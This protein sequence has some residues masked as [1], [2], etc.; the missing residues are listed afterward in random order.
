VTVKDFDELETDRLL[1]E[2][3]ASLHQ[4]IE[5]LRSRAVAALSGRSGFQERRKTY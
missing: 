1:P 2:L 3:R 4:S 5:R